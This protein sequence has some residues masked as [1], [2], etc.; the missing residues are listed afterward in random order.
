[1]TRL[2]IRNA[3]HEVR[4]PL[5]SII[6][7]LEVAL[8]ETL[9]EPARH[10]LQRSLQASKSLVFV[11]NDLLNLTEAEDV[12]FSVHE[13]NVDL[14]DILSE[15]VAAFEIEAAKRKTH[16]VL[17]ADISIPWIVI[18]DPG[19]LRTVLSNLLANAIK[20]SNEGVVRIIMVETSTTKASSSIEISFQDE[21]TGLS[22]Q[23]LNSIF[24]DF[25]RIMDDDETRAQP[26]QTTEIRRHEIGLGLAITARF[27]RLNNGQISISS[28]GEGKGTT[29]SITLPFRK[30]LEGYLGKRKLSHS[31]PLPTPPTDPNFT[32]GHSASGSVFMDSTPELSISEGSA[33]REKLVGAGPSNPPSNPA[34]SYDAK[35]TSPSSSASPLSPSSPERGR[36]PFP[37]STSRQDNEKLNILVAEDN[38][39][40]S[41]LLETRLRRRGHEVRVAGNGQ[42]CFDAFTK[43]PATYDVVLMDIQVSNSI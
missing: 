14:R 9:G 3:G 19:N 28:D 10:H 12:D 31:H 5:N 36:Y 38:P 22:E 40:N 1:M 21:G 17:E 4:T 26:M 33:T 6:N 8:E 35:S 24:Q 16:V 32:H 43:G 37:I 15:V 7:Y 2:L 39:L 30:A 27:V 41:Q 20:H 25:E 13:D 18:C 42:D 29:V 23:Q 11:V 34:T